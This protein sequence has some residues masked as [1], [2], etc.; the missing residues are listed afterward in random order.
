MPIEIVCSNCQ[1][2]LRVADEHAGKNARCPKCGNI[3]PIPGTPPTSDGDPMEPAAAF[4]PSPD[5]P[6]STPKVRPESSTPEYSNPYSTP[7]SDFSSPGPQHLPRHRGEII[8]VL[9]ISSLLCCPFLGIASIIM[10]NNDLRQ[11]DRGA[12][13]PGG[14][15][16]TMAGK[17]IS[18]IALVLG[19][20][21]CLLQVVLSI[22][23][24][25]Q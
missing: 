9:G 12:M 16:M 6:W 10:A 4:Q 3:V 24:G 14:H 21:G 22:A 23:A 1:S 19:A 17:I 8:L 2:L 18:I 20:C 7:T 5:S 25:V 11:M 15:G 13:D